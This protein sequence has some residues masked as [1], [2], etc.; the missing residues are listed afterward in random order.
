MWVK[1]YSPTVTAVE[2]VKR[3]ET[4]ARRGKLYY[5]RYVVALI[6]TMSPLFP[7]PF[8]G[9]LE[10]VQVGEW[11]NEGA[12]YRKPKH[13]KGSVEREVDAYL[14]RR[15]LIRSGALGPRELSKSTRNPASSRSG[16]KAR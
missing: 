7:V 13:D 8:S 15:R 11:A 12:M 5:M 10:W 2:V 16:V 6:P 1:V 3:A 9:R 14:K 4:R